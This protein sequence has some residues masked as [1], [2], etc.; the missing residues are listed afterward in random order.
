MDLDTP[1]FP[2]CLQDLAHV[3]LDEVNAHSRALRLLAGSGDSEFSSKD[4]D[5]QMG[6]ALSFIERRIPVSDQAYSDK[7]PGPMVI[8]RDTLSAIANLVCGRYRFAAPEATREMLVAYGQARYFDVEDPRMPIGA[9]SQQS[10]PVHMAVMY[11]SQPAT[12]AFIDLG[13]RLFDPENG[14]RYS[15]VDDVDGFLRFAEQYIKP[16]TALHA[17]METAIHAR[18]MRKRIEERTEWTAGGLELAQAGH[19][20]LPQPVQAAPARVATSRSRRAGV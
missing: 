20:E 14:D 5:L 16:R 9:A 19:G 18:I 17:L 12:L 3:T 4:F 1:T 15:L 2:S 6:A 8:R 13:A 7:L 10:T 11:T